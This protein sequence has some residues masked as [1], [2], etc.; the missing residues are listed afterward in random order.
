MANNSFQLKAWTIALVTAIGGLAAQGTEKRFIIIAF[1][2]I[3]CLWILDTYYL[4]LERQY[5]L[6]YRFIADKKDCEI[7]FKMGLSQMDNLSVK[8]RKSLSTLNCFFSSTELIFYMPLT[9]AFIVIMVV[10]KIF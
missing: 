6:L 10:L 7:D 1:V 9:I 5:R 8:D 3:I 2:P 4:R